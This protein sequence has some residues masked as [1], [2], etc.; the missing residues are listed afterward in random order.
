MD[1]KALLPRQHVL[2]HVEGR[3]RREILRALVRPLVQDGLVVDER[4]FINHLERR[5]D[6]ITT[7]LDRGIAFPHARSEAARR[8]AL[9]VGV[10]DEPGLVFN[11]EREDL[12]R[13]FFLIAVPSFAP[14]AHLPVLQFLANFAHQR[15]R[16][17]KL[18]SAKT[19]AQLIRVLAT[20]K[21]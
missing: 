20:F 7:Q 16:V 3:N 13:V 1:L 6:E 2:F 11:V 4:S 21:G 10:T 14:T 5:E 17:E 19:P 12:C 8:L 15:P 18:L 9:V